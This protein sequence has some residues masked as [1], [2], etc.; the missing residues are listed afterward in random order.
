MNEEKNDIKALIR[1]EQM[2]KQF[3]LAL[4]RHLS[5][6]RFMRIALTAVNKNP[7]LLKCTKESLLGCLLDCSQLGLEPDGRKA[8]LIPYES[9]KQ[10]NYY[11]TLIIDYKGLVDL[12]RR[13]GEIADIHADVV[14]QNDVFSYEYGNN[15]SLIHKPTLVNR[16]DV[17]GAYSFVRLKDGAVSYEVMNIDDIK[18]IRA[19]SK[20][21]DDGPW[22]TDW[23]EMAKK[24]IFRRHAKWLPVSVEFQDAI[25]KDYDVPIDISPVPNEE[26]EM[27]KPKRQIAPEPVKEEINE[28]TEELIED[29]AGLEADM[30]GIPSRTP[31]TRFEACINDDEGSAIE[32]EE[33]EP[34]T[35]NKRLIKQSDGD[36]LCMKSKFNSSC[37]HC[38]GNIEKGT[39]VYYSKIQGVFHLDCV[40]FESVNNIKGGKYGK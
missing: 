23:N 16:G 31:N 32:P 38:G 18:K 36:F 22:V 39:D 1:S 15:G 19:R 3:Q 34:K 17:V 27:P 30:L 11:C 33:D 14:Y 26:I 9:K 10:N 4:P 28:E 5:P 25:D 12:A 24:T 2:I 8:H 7:K 29:T 37:K 40:E 21:K 13:S 35:P 20:A 6:E